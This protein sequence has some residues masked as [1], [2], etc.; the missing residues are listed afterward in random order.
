MK[1]QLQFDEPMDM[2]QIKAHIEKGGRFIVYY[3]CISL[4]ALTLT[5]L[6]PAF[7]VFSDESH[8]KHRNKYNLITAI[9]GWWGIPWGIK[10]SLKAMKL[11]NQGGLDVTE[12]IMPNLKKEHL[13]NGI[14]DLVEMNLIFSKPDYW[15]L[16]AYEKVLNRD[17]GRDLSVLKIVAA[18]HLNTGEHDV[19]RTIGIE[20]KSD[21][22][23]FVEK[24]K[25]ALWR[26]F[27]KGTPFL[28]IDLSK[29]TK[30][31]ELLQKQGTT[32]VSRSSG[33]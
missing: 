7:F 31:S 4:L 22:D 24:M 10:L 15:D 8:K 26:E 16:K 30:I 28:F 11:N 2:E 13:E 27:R 18:V 6:S 5:R 21:F 1:Y 17:I 12:D 23:G 3:Y 32:L 14:I 9:F 25:T 19:E 33:H 20:V 29:K